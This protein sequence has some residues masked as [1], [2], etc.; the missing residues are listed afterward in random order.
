[1]DLFAALR[2]DWMRDV[3]VELNAAIGITDRP[4]IALPSAALIAI[5]GPQ[6]VLKAA[7]GAVAGQLSAGHRHEWTVGPTNDLEVSNHECM[8]ESDRTKRL[9]AVVGVFHQ[10]DAYFGDFHSRSP[11]LIPPGFPPIHSRLSPLPSQ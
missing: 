9:Q 5:V 6:V 7:L 11:G 10:L 4:I 8:I 1:L 3:G 2:V